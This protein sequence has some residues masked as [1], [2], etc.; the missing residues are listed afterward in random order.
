MSIFKLKPCPFCGSDVGQP[1]GNLRDDP[2]DECNLISCSTIQ[3]ECS[4]LGGHSIWAEGHDAKSCADAWNSRHDHGK[5]ALLAEMSGALAQI[6][7][8]SARPDHDEFPNLAKAYD[9]GLERARAV[10]ESYS[11]QLGNG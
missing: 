7:S 4:E 1:F 6:M 11:R 5:D 3:H 9:A 8:S 10:Q 2:D